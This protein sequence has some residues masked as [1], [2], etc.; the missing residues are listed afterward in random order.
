MY[1]M[2]EVKVTNETGKSKIDF[3]FYIYNS[4]S[5]GGN[6]ADIVKET[7][8]KKQNLNFYV[9]KL[10]Q[11][12]IIERNNNKN[13]YMGWK[14]LKI[15]SKE[16]LEKEVKVKTKR[17][18]SKISLGTSER[19][20]TNLH[21]LQIKFPILSGTIKDKDWE[22][23][24]KLK[25]WIPKYTKLSELG[26]LRVK[27]N[28]NKSITIWAEQRNIKNLNE[29]HN[30][31]YQIRTYIYNYFKLKHNVI[32]DH[33]NAEVKNLDLATED[34]NSESMRGKG[35][36]FSLDL[37]KQAQ[38]IFNNDNYKAKAWIDGTPFN[39]SAETND[40]DW[41]REYLN[42]PFNIKHLIYSLP[43]LEEY[44][45]NL[46]LHIK[47]QQEQLKTQKENQQTQKEIRLLL[48]DLRDRLKEK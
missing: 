32:L 39:F 30:L 10:K 26:G 34:K 12:G 7:G 28:N 5:K 11:L 13:V 43:A 20:I 4:I 25:N 22:T 44:N 31:A 36:K 21:A 9:N 45:K 40:L 2:K 24:E 1:F 29:V 46:M 6:I 33:L 47:V 8:V 19:P 15:L 42:M 27:N 23:K 17:G 3:Y 41:K 16:E 48:D 18:K 37:G 14:L 35:E 38:K